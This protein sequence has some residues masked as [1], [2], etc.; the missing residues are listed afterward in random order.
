MSTRAILNTWLLIFVFIPVMASA[1][2][3]GTTLYVDADASAGGDGLSWSTAFKYLQ[4]DLAAAVSS[5]EIRMAQGAYKPDRDEG[6]PTGTGSR[7][8]TFQLISGVAVYGGYAG[9]GEPDPDAWDVSLYETILSGDLDAND[10]PVAN[11]DDLLDEPTRSEN[12]YHVVTGSGTDETVVLDG[13]TITGGNANGS[14][15]TPQANGGRVRCY[16][17]SPTLTNCTLTDNS[18]VYGGGIHSDNYSNPTLINCTFSG[19]WAGQGSGI[20]SE[21]YSDSTLINCKFSGNS[22][23]FGGGMYNVSS[24]FPILIDCI[25]RNNSADWVGGGIY[26]YPSNPGYS[27]IINCIFIGSIASE[28]GGATFER[29]CASPEFVNCTFYRNSA[30]SLGGAIA[31]YE[32]S[33]MSLADCI[34]WA[35]NAEEGPQISLNSEA[36]V[37]ISYCDIQG[38]KIDIYGAQEANLDWGS[39]SIDSDPLFADAGNDDYH[40][41]SQAGRWNPDTNEWV[42]DGSTSPCIDAGDPNSDWTAE[43]WPHG[44]RINMG[45]Y[46]GTPEAS[47]SPSDV[48]NNC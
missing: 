45:A 9:D 37:S 32:Q 22:S 18:A 13:F 4:D 3:A 44:K 10:V 40:L 8:A 14:W 17:S 30:N 35:N 16:D 11:P 26:N 34:L 48:G 46:G 12:S 41:K 2:L 28:R 29:H 23:T 7:E 20:N 33:F 21:Y 27:P 1:A 43:L 15:S 24:S 38:G 36:N 39:G 47:M 42:T 31:N 6:N 25:F 5:D 19:N